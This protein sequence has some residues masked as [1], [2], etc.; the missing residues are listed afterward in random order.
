MKKDLVVE[1]CIYGTT[2]GKTVHMA[3]IESKK[4]VLKVDPSWF[5]NIRDTEKH[6][7][8]VTQVNLTTYFAQI[9]FSYLGD[10][11]IKC[12]TLV[13]KLLTMA[14]ADSNGLVSLNEAIRF[15]SLLLTREA[16]MQATMNE[17]KSAVHFY[18]YCGGS[19]IVERVHIAN[20]QLIDISNAFAGFFIAPLFH[21]GLQSFF[22]DLLSKVIDSY[23][24]ISAIHEY[25]YV[26][27][28]KLKK[29]SVPSFEQRVD[30]VTGMIKLVY[31]FVSFDY[32]E[33]LLCD[34][35]FDNV[36][37]SD[38]KNFSMVR[39]TDFDE[40]FAAAEVFQVKPNKKTC[41][42][43]MDCAKG[44]YSVGIRYHEEC[45]SFCQDDGF[46]SMRMKKDNLAF[47]CSRMFWDVFFNSITLALS[48]EDLPS[49][50]ALSIIDILEECEKP[51]LY[52][53]VEERLIYIQKVS[54]KFNEVKQLIKTYKMQ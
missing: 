43:D 13:A 41:K 16:F 11:C 48:V 26:L 9:V 2:L 52:S 39:Q 50:V 28:K 54:Y 25:V 21:E 27:Y 14:D 12:D 3:T 34:L 23:P 1:E 53:N 35:N 44:V 4:V 33:I 18:G 36:G 45:S 22:T 49:K 38:L 46:C 51:V 19:Y 24:T 30:F 47:L 42:T 6:L 7:Q 31:D 17:T 32:G 8:K 29:E 15:G 20:S 10:N 40:V 5:K 37:F